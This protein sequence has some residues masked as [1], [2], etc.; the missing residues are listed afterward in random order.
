MQRFREWIAKSD[1]S[2]LESP[3]HTPTP[4]RRMPETTT[5][6]SGWSQVLP[7]VE[8]RTSRGPSRRSS[9]SCSSSCPCP[10][11]HLH[12]HG[13]LKFE[14]AIRFGDGNEFR[15]GR[16]RSCLTVHEF[17]EFFVLAVKGLVLYFGGLEPGLGNHNERMR[18]KYAPVRVATCS[19]AESDPPLRRGLKGSAWTLLPPRFA[20]LAFLAAAFCAFS[21]GLG[22]ASA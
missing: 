1:T 6:W 10:L 12:L 19:S 13:F 20:F 18:K 16:R 9:S 22:E 11:E 14:I 17:L 4:R 5:Y 21:T 2:A 7:G 8:V 15:T 3:A